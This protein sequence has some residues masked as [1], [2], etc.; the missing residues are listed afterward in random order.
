VAWFSFRLRKS[1][2]HSPAFSAG[3]CLAIAAGVLSS[4]NWLFHNQI[5]LLP[6]GIWLLVWARKFL[7]GAQRLLPLSCQLTMA[8]YAASAALI[9]YAH[10]AGFRSDNEI[11]V[12]LPF[13]SIFLAPPVFFIVALRSAIYVMRRPAAPILQ[14]AEQQTG[15]VG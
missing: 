8:W 3:L 7:S 14:G 1:E 13:L 2:P 9:V 4:P 11:L 12:G 6:V 10:F 15:A 5:M